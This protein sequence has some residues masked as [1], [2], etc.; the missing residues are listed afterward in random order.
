MTS[1]MLPYQDPLA[2]IIIVAGEAKDFGSPDHFAN[3]VLAAPLVVANATGPVPTSVT[4][5]WQ[6]HTYEFFPNPSKRGSSTPN[7]YRLPT[8]D[9][10]AIDVSPPFAY[11]GPHLNAALGSDTVELKYNDYVLEYNFS[12]DSIKRRG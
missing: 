11:S 1:G 2:P 6:T 9:G 12:D 10:V 4:F 3:A 5:G 8:V 7:R